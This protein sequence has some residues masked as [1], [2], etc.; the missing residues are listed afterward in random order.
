MVTHDNKTATGRSPAL[1]YPSNKTSAAVAR[2]SGRVHRS[3]QFPLT[4]KGMCPAAVRIGKFRICSD[5]FIETFYRFIALLPFGVDGADRI[6]YPTVIWLEGKR[7]A[8]EVLSS[9]PFVLVAN[10][11][12]LQN[13]VGPRVVRIKHGHPL[14]DIRLV[15]RVVVQVA[16]APRPHRMT[17]LRCAAR[18]APA[19]AAAMLGLRARRRT[20]SRTAPCGNRLYSMT[21]V[22]QVQSVKPLASC[23]RE[24]HRARASSRA[25][26]IRAP[27]G[28]TPPPPAIAPS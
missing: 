17:M 14:S 2:S 26:P 21:F 10:E 16:P 12:I 3:V 1:R 23:G 11:N 4:D 27:R 8:I 5:C 7:I 25:R 28:A 6:Q 19:P 18:A 15:L 9:I 22:L 13:D 20:G 24:R